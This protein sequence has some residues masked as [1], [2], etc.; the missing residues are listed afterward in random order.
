MVMSYKQSERN[1]FLIRSWIGSG[2]EPLPDAARGI[3]NRSIEAIEV[4]DACLAS[5]DRI[6]EVVEYR[7]RIARGEPACRGIML[8][9]TPAER[10]GRLADSLAAP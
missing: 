7:A 4:Y 10:I 3:L 1:V 2:K 9:G 6:V 5:C 8:R